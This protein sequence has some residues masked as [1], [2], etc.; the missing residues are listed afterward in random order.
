LVTAVHSLA[1][2]APPLPS[3][4]P[5]E[6]PV[7]FAYLMRLSSTLAE[8]ELSPQQQTYLLAE[9]K[10][11]LDEDGDDPAARR[12][13][14]QLLGV[15][16]NRHDVTW[17]TRTEI[18]NLLA[19]IE[20][21]SP[22]PATPSPQSPQP[23][24]A[25]R[26]APPVRT[27]STPEHAAQAYPTRPAGESTGSPP[28][29]VGADSSARSR[30]GSGSQPSHANG[31]DEDRRSRKRWMIGG[32]AGLAAVVAIVV[33]VLVVA[34]RPGSPPSSAP[35]N[36]PPG[37]LDSVLLGAP[38]VSAIMGV[39]GMEPADRT[40]AMRTF[41]ATLSNPACLGALNP[42]EDS[43]YGNSGYTGVSGLALHTTGV[44]PPHRVY[45]AAVG[46]PSAQR[47]QAFVSTSAAN[48]KACAGQTV[49]LT[50]G[51]Q[52]VQW[53]FGDVTGASPKIAQ[54]H[55]QVVPGGVSCQRALSA[56]SN[57]VVD[58]QACAPVI[59]NES[60]RIANQMTARVG[61]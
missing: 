4:L 16:R 51:N 7:P 47:A 39:T 54:P 44:G 27:R 55:N 58:V 12:D 49:T 29:S 31:P 52:T 46:F 38:D 19:S 56:V 13:I 48:W 17:R 1:A 60:S 43:V 26:P 53:S 36:A 57:I 41:Q 5:A 3:P 33:V 25:A 50:E 24:T 42:I 61:Q 32:A 37:G 28:P 6:P 18:D 14:A 45:Q 9:L 21:T 8:Q 34:Q 35:T 20:S 2:Q 11:G 23:V 22:P 30:T 40:Q 10:S 15:L 59:T